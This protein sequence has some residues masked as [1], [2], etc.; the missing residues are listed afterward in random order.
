MT[1]VKTYIYDALKESLNTCDKKDL[2]YYFNDLHA[3]DYFSAYTDGEYLYNTA[4]G[5]EKDTEV[6]TWE[7]IEG[8]WDEVLE[9][10]LIDFAEVNMMDDDL[11]ECTILWDDENRRYDNIDNATEVLS[12][13]WS[14]DG[15]SE[16]SG[17]NSSIYTVV[18]YLYETGKIGCCLGEIALEGI[19]KFFGATHVAHLEENEEHGMICSFYRY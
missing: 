6:C 1:D 18:S 19:A 11:E 16:E 15:T 13:V 5:Q 14:K 2:D 4:D 3:E 10:A 17:F 12:Q 7:E 9:K 8:V